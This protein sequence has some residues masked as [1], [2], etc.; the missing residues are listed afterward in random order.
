[1]GPLGKR[2]RDYIRHEPMGKLDLHQLQHET[3]T[4]TTPISTFFKPTPR[5]SIYAQQKRA[6][7]W[8]PTGGPNTIIREILKVRQDAIRQGRPAPTEITL[9]E[10][11]QRRLKQYVKECGTVQ[12]NDPTAYKVFGMIIRGI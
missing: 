2:G 5:L 12:T 11:Q 4:M 1:M 8:P 10:D 3:D 9:T 6:G 7:E